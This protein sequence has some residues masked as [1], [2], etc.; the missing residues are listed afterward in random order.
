MMARVNCESCVGCE[1]L[2]VWERI[3][4]L[5]LG[6]QSAFSGHRTTAFV[7]TLLTF[8][9]HAVK[10]LK[11]TKDNYGRLTCPPGPELLANVSSM[12]DRSSPLP[13]NDST[14]FWASA[15]SLGVLNVAR[16]GGVII[17]PEEYHR[18][19]ILA[20]LFILVNFFHCCNTVAISGWVG[21]RKW[22]KILEGIFRVLGTG[23]AQSRLSIKVT[24]LMRHQKDSMYWIFQFKHWNVHWFY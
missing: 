9:T 7:L 17:V 22:S 10:S 12:S 21:V 5:Q 13:W 8:F 14:H 20:R 11:G 3:L 1:G 24:A 4:L 19:P 16:A 2:T 18:C 23:H 15:M 6:I